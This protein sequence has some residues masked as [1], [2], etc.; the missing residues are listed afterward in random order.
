MDN[1]DFQIITYTFMSQYPNICMNVRNAD[2]GDTDVKYNIGEW[3]CHHFYLIQ[4]IKKNEKNLIK[5]CL[6]FYSF[7]F[8][9]MPISFRQKSRG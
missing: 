4:K 5:V 9:P 6:N 2:N 7:A 3:F 8:H 1:I